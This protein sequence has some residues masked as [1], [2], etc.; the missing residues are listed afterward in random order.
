MKKANVD[1]SAKNAST[2]LIKDQLTEAYRNYFQLKA[3]QKHLRQTHLEQLA[4]AIA[5]E[6]NTAQ[7]NILRLLRERE[8]QRT[9]AKKIRY[10]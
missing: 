5:E 10:L 8:K 7:E 3:S 2:I 6:N 9:S 4:E 1:R